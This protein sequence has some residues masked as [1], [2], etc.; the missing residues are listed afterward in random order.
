MARPKLPQKLRPVAVRIAPARSK[1]VAKPGAVPKRRAAVKL[2]AAV[3]PRA[4]VTQQKVLPAEEAEALIRDI[5]TRRARIADDFYEIGVALNRLS[6]RPL[7]TSLGYANFDDLLARRRV[8]G[9]VQAF[10]LMAVTQAFD[11]QQALRLGVEKSYALVRYVAATPA[12]DLA[13]SLAA[14]NARIGAKRLRA[15]SA[16]ELRDATKRLQSRA[17]ADDYDLKEARATARALQK[18]LRADGAKTAKV[19]AHREGSGVQLRID[20]DVKD[21]GVLLD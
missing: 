7:Y 21:A 5:A 3:T 17:P 4:V 14:T 9:R 12:H 16:K 8:L 15:M 10:K 1:P 20:L 2:R 6:S 11:K 19:R 18:K 13:R